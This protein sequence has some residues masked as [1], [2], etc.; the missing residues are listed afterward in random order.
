MDILIDDLLIDN[1]ENN[2]F[3]FVN[4]DGKE[5]DLADSSEWTS[6]DENLNVNLSVTQYDK[7][8]NTNDITTKLFLDDEL[9]VL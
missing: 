1:D 3:M 2:E 7:Y 8:I 4:E 5:T 6:A 9:L